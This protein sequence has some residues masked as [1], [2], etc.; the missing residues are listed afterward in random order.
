MNETGSWRDMLNIDFHYLQI[1]AGSI[2][3]LIFVT[4]T[5]PMVIKAVK[6]KNLTSYSLGN[7]ALSNMGNFI[8]WMYVVGLPF[9]PAWF[10]HCFNTLTTLLMLILYL[11]Y[12]KGCSIYNFSECAKSFPACLS[13]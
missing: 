11:R 5:L 10:L 3:S 13:N 2:S 8:Y 7:I 4:G 9:G 6:T 12:E 1:L